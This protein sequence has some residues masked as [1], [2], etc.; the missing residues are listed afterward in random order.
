MDGNFSV[1]QVLDLGNYVRQKLLS[2]DC[3]VGIPLILGWFRFLGR[4]GKL[5]RQK[6]HS[7]NAVSLT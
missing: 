4:M 5:G 7:H 2:L 1:V 6:G 3:N